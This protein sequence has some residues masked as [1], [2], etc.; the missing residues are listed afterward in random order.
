[1]FTDQVRIKVTAG[2][3]G[4]GCT[5]FRREKYI[6][7][8][9]PDGGDG[10]DG[11]SVCFE[12]TPRMTSLMDLKYH[13]HWKAVRGV[14]GKGSDCHGRCAEDLVIQVPCG[15]VV[16]DLH[17]NELLCD[18]VEPGQ[19]HRIAQGGRGGKGNARF[20]TSTNRAPKFA[21]KGQ[22]GEEL[23]LL[24][25]LKLIAEVGIVGLPNAGKSTFLAAVSAAHPK[26]ADYPFTTLT[27][28]LGIAKLGGY[29]TLSVADIPGIIEGA[30]QGKG[31]GH[32]F[33]RHIERT[34]VLLFM[35]DLGDP[36]PMH[37]RE[38]LENE[39]EEYSTAFADRPRVYALNKADVTENRE[40]M[41]ELERV[42]SPVYFI[43]AATGEG[44]PELLEDLW[45]L[46][47][48]TRREEVPGET[49]TVERE[50]T[51]EAPFR[52]FRV[53]GGFR[54]EGPR[55]LRTVQMTNFENAEAVRHLQH[56]L[57]R[58]G[59]FKALK[60]FGAKEGDTIS[61]GDFEMDYHPD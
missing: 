22:P 38:V 59:L 46:V 15:T 30:A 20:A 31:L 18:L 5:S 28:N 32:D 34:R 12:A 51:F 60:R 39:L 16:R 11:G 24:L 43:S 37:T 45:A 47:D 27:P 19:R 2:A 40:R 13:A 8:G 17:T 50:Y 58:T 6:P 33:L 29:R 7:M 26:I 1:M 35:I 48:L 53:P 36:D 49:V 61:I 56:S 21:E 3:G 9:G 44:V 10:G 54:I 52:V 14:H 42:F 41:A 4:D 23:D 55:V 25:E 57:E